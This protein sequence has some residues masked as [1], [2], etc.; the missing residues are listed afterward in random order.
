MRVE[1][2]NEQSLNMKSFYFLIVSSI[3]LVMGNC[4]GHTSMRKY[5]TWH[6]RRIEETI[7]LHAKYPI[8]VKPHTLIFRPMLKLAGTRGR[9]V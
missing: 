2:M 6:A 7:L 3:Q 4:Y 8:S 5:L 1:L 9:A